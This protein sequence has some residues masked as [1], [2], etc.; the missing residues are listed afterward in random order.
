MLYINTRQA[1]RPNKAERGRGE[2]LEQGSTVPWLVFAV[3][4]FRMEEVI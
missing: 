1:R 3:H 4:I 2:G